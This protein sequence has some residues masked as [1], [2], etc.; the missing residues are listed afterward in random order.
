MFRYNHHFSSEERGLLNYA[1]PGHPPIVRNSR[2]YAFFVAGTAIFPHDIN[3]DDFSPW[4]HNGNAQNPTCYRTKVRK[5][6][7]I[8]D[9]LGSQFQVLH[10]SQGKQPKKS[11]GNRRSPKIPKSAYFL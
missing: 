1:K 7:V 10:G 2:A 3:R 9:E 5:V 11:D 8:C 6:G 4:S